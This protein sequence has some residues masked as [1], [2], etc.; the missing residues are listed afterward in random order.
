MGL[1]EGKKRFKFLILFNKW[2][3]TCWPSG[4]W[5]HFFFLCYV[6]LLLSLFNISLRETYRIVFIG[7]GNLALTKCVFYFFFS[8]AGF[9]DAL[10]W[11]PKVL[12]KIVNVHKWIQTKNICIWI[13][14]FW[15][16]FKLKNKES[17][18]FVFS[19]SCLP[20]I[21]IENISSAIIMLFVLKDLT[22]FWDILYTINWRSIRSH[23][24]RAHTW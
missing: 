11:L 15:L 12:N 7:F 20:A 2:Q 13:K 1:N 21:N 22:V 10:K 4:R 19:F 5:L 6:T 17:V 16:K 8:Y 3:L 14:S 23:T 24:I 18:R 9:D